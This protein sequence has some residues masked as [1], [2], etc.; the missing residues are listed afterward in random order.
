MSNRGIDANENVALAIGNHARDHLCH[1]KR[2]RDGGGRTAGGPGVAWMVRAIG[3]GNEDL[4]VAVSPRA[5]L[6]GHRVGPRG[7]SKPRKEIGFGA[8]SQHVVAERGLRL[9]L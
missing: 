4:A 1:V 5:P 2:L 8:G 6:P 3:D 7:T 9:V